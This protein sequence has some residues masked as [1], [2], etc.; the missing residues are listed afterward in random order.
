MN[1]EDR[2]EI[3]IEIINDKEPEPDETFEVI[4]S[5]PKNGLKLGTPSRGRYKYLP[6]NQLEA[7]YSKVF[8]FIDI[9]AAM[10]FCGLPN[11]K[12]QEQSTVFTVYMDIFTVIYFR[13]FFFLRTTEI[14]WFTVLP[15]QE[16]FNAYILDV[17]TGN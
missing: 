12:M 4:L 3:V 6:L 16:V 7:I 14:K 17:S 8:A 9:V 1:K 2:K 15:F 11:G 10:Y 13:Y 5:N